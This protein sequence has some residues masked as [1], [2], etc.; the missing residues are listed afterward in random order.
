MSFLVKED[1]RVKVGLCSFVLY[2]PFARVI[3]ILKVAG[4]RGCEANGFGWGSGPGDGRLILS[5]LYWFIAINA[6][7]AHVWFCEVQD[8]R[9]KK[10]MLYHL[11]IAVSGLKGFVIKT[12]VP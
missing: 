9:D 1:N 11:E 8:M 6:V 12:I 7:I 4:E 3:R 10:E 5:E 2:P